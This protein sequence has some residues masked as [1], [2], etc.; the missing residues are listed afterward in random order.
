MIIIL[1]EFI[2]SMLDYLLNFGVNVWGLQAKIRLK[3]S[4]HRQFRQ[5]FLDGNRSSLVEFMLF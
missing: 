5:I 3:P 4:E 2:A 1:V